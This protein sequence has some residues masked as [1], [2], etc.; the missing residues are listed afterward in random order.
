MNI[1]IRLFITIS[2]PMFRYA[3]WILIFISLNKTLANHCENMKQQDIKFRFYRYEYIVTK[4]S[5]F[6]NI[7]Y[8]M[9][10]L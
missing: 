7:R 1:D 3:Q 2:R 10:S 8:K 9:L 5:N 6:I 4:I